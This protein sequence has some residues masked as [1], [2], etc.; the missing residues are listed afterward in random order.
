MMDEDEQTKQL[1][2]VLE[3][4]PSIELAVGPEGGWSETDREMLVSAGFSGARLGPY[5]LRSDTAAISSIAVV[6]AM[7]R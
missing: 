2:D 4:P 3:R 6:R 1:A 7:C 5:T